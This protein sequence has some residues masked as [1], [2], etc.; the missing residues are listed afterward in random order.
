MHPSGVARDWWPFN[1]GE[2][3]PRS[4]ADVGVLVGSPGGIRASA[5][6][7]RTAEKGMA[8]VRA[9]A[10]RL[11]RVTSG[12]SWKGDAFESFRVAMAKSPT[13]A[14]VD[15]A[16]QT[17]GR[18]AGVLER[19]ADAIEDTQRRWNNLRTELDGLAVPA[20]GDIP[21]TLKP[22]V[23]SIKSQLDTTHHNYEVYLGAAARDFDELDD[24]PKFAKDE[25]GADYWLKA[26]LHN[27]GD[28]FEGIWAAFKE[29]GGALKSLWEL[30]KISQWDDKW[31]EFWQVL[32]YAADDPLEFAKQLGLAAIDWETL[33]ENPAKW[34]GKLA[35]T[36]VAAFFT[37]GG[38]VAVTRGAKLPKQLAALAREIRRLEALGRSRKQIEKLRSLL[39]EKVHGTGGPGRGTSD[40]EWA[41][42]YAANGERVWRLLAL[43]T[44]INPNQGFENCVRTTIAFELAMR[45][46]ARGVNNLP[47]VTALPGDPDVTPRAF[48]KML[49]GKFRPVKGGLAVLQRHIAGRPDG[50]RGIVVGRLPNG[51]VHAVNTINVDGRPVFID[52]QK[53]DPANPRP[54]AAHKTFTEM[55]YLE[56]ADQ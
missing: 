3:L 12:E 11:E 36:L 8:E 55:Y 44:E 37:A 49:G 19:L 17:M 31:D 41:A 13:V 40:A 26:T 2:D 42:W 1:D 34:L 51:M 45:A 7:L 4:G 18:A 50:T 6:M 23:K 46:R 52:T 21:D 33:K 43:A 15:N 9:A 30:R 53:I 28:F 10:A 16:K 39:D 24:R 47:R 38:A 14:D 32:Q 27:I 56:I 48:T 20:S 22:Q 5:L 54:S 35:P 29:L 25:S